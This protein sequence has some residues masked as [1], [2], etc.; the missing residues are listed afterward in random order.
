MRSPVRHHTLLQL[1]PISDIARM[2]FKNIFKILIILC[3]FTYPVTE[4]DVFGNIVYIKLSAENLNGN[5]RTRF[6]GGAVQRHF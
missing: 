5:M 2:N 3:C 1:L 4:Q 6:L